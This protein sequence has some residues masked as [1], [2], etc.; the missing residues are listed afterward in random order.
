MGGFA[1]GGEE[2]AGKVLSGCSIPPQRLEAAPDSGS[3]GPSGTRALPKS[4]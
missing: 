2:V 4:T 1:F 3:Y